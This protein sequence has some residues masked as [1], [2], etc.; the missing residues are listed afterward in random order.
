MIR[1]ILYFEKR[2]YWEEQTTLPGLK[3]Q[4]CDSTPGMKTS[5]SW[6]LTPDHEGGNSMRVSKLHETL[7]INPSCWQSSRR[8]TGIN[9]CSLTINCQVQQFQQCRPS[10]TLLNHD[11]YNHHWPS[12]IIID[13]YKPLLSLINYQLNCY[14]PPSI[15]HYKP[16]LFLSHQ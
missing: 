5:L 3:K 12:L 15:N 6:K 4:L 7:Q 13:R 2:P 8:W 1:G 16:S 10:S 9:Q 14:S 11:L